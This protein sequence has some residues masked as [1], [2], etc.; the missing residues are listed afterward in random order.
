MDDVQPWCEA[1]ASDRWIKLDFFHFQPFAQ[2]L[3]GDNGKTL[4]TLHANLTENSGFG[5]GFNPL[6]RACAAG[7]DFPIP[8]P[9]WDRMICGTLTIK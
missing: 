8:Q 9:E 2:S 3:R 4:Q 6:A 1:F 7:A 5:M